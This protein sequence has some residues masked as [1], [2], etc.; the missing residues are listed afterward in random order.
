MDEYSIDDILPSPSAGDDP[1]PASTNSFADGV[2]PAA[3]GSGELQGNTTVTDGYLQSENYVSATSGWRL[4][5]TSAELNVSTALHS[6]DIPDTTSADSFHVD[7]TG[8]AWWGAAAIGSAVAKIL[9]TGIATFTNVSI[10]GGS[11]TSTPIS[12]IPNNSSTDISLLEK[13]HTMVFSVT[14]A[15]TIAWTSGTITLSNGRTFSISSGNTGNMSALTYIYLDPGVSST[16][17]QTTTTAATALGANKILIGC[18]Q[19]NTVTASYIPYGPGQPLVDG[20]NIGALSIVAANIA[21]STITAAKLTVSQLSAITADLGAITAGSIV[22]PSGGFIRSGQTAY[23]TGTGFYL[24]NDSGTPRFSIG[25]SSGNRITWDGTTLTI[26]GNQINIQIFTSTGTWTKPTSAQSVDVVLVGAGAGGGSGAN[27]CTA[28]FGGGSG[29]GGGGRS[30]IT[31]PASVLSST[32]PVTVGTGG[33]GGALVNS[34]GGSGNGGT[35]G[36]DTKFDTRLIA[37]GGAAGARGEQGSNPAG[38]A[39][40]A[41][42]FTGGDGGTAG[43]NAPSSIFAPSGGGGGGPQNSTSGFNGGTVLAIPRT[44]GAGG[45]S[46]G[47]GANGDSATTN[48][49]TGGSGGGGGG[50]SNSGAAGAG[51]NGGTYGAGGGG[52]GGAPGSQNSGAGGAG[53]NGFAIVIT[54]LA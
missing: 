34:V 42:M 14:D 17:L 19:N 44:G 39:G 43:A 8:N 38:G 3:L 15:D 30:N 27:N 40:G 28:G 31:F 53:A 11:I 9:K 48:D 51:G 32:H 21:A 33:A 7:S 22:L 45:T 12:S 1:T 6:L 5:P 23:N 50:G 24:G 29:G 47:A 54:Y 18:A 4:T 52:G 35:A 20:S 49:P 16:V 26:V 25:S 37:R 36:G 46:S 41:G 10:T 13:T 2:G